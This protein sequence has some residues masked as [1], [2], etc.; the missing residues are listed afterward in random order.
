MINMK[1]QRSYSM[2]VRAASAEATRRRIVE[3]AVDQ[4][5]SRFRSDIRLED[6][7]RGAE[8]SVQTVLRLFGSRSGLLELALGQL[9]GEIT[10]QRGR[11]APGGIDGGVS[12]LFDHYEQVGDLVI[13][14][15]AEEGD[16]GVQPILEGGRVQ[17]REWVERQFGPQV[18]VLEPAEREWI[19]DALVCACDVYTWKLLRRDMGRSRVDA[20]S[21]MARMVRAIL[22][23]T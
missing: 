20:E 8:V 6:V 7:A 14:N 5:R 19:V 9:R 18:T 21:T 2:L 10:A 22:G 17:H 15:L 3:V 13:R 23:G 16:P 11:A 1:Q 12:A 4:V